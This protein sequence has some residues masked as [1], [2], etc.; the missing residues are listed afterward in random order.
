MK[1]D[2]S[3]MP[4]IDQLAEQY[5]SGKGMPRAERKGTPDFAGILTMKQ[6][7]AEA[8]EAPRFSKH[9]LGRLSSRSITLTDEQMERLTEGAGRA[10]AKGI[11]ESLVM[12]DDLAF[13]VNIRNNTVV[14][15]MD[16]TLS[17]ESVYTNI[18]GA[19]IA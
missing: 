18:D 8:L 6:E 9:A 14:T 4:S 17:E 12:V 2:Q 1:I 10:Q 3:T 13:I 15:A 16:S 19:V 11:N 7:Q 5:L